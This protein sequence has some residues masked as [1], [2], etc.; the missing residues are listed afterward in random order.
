MLNGFL[1]NYIPNETPSLNFPDAFWT[2]TYI[3]FDNNFNGYIVL[4]VF[5]TEDSFNNKDMPL[6]FSDAVR[7]ISL[8]N[9]D[10]FAFFGQE[11][12]NPDTIKQL[13]LSYIEKSPYFSDL[14]MS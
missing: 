12:I 13:I 1:R 3:Q 2:W 11:N 5:A 8:V 9:E 14:D 6:P 4:K 7:H 10:V